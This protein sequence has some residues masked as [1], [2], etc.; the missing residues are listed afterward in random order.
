[1]AKGETKKTN[2]MLDTSTRRA[3]QQSEQLN[4]Q[5]AVRNEQAWGNSVESRDQALA[6]FTNLTGM[7]MEQQDRLRGTNFSPINPNSGHFGEAS[8][9]YRDFIKTGGI[10]EAKLH[11]ADPVWNEIMKTGGWS[12]A[13]K[14]GVTGDVSGLRTIGQYG[15]SSQAN[16]DRLRGGGVYDEFAKT[17]GLSAGNI[18]DI[19]SRATSPIAA[20]YSAARSDVDRQGRIG[21]TSAGHGA[22]VAR[23]ARDRARDAGA[24][25]LDAELGITDRVTAGRQ[26]G[27]QGM[28]GSEA[29]IASNQIA[30]LGAASNIQSG[31]ENA[32]TA[33]RL[34]AGG[35][36]DASQRAI[37]GM[38][39]Q[40]KMFGGQG[41]ESI[42]AQEAASRQ[43]AAEMAANNERYIA[44]MDFSARSQS[45]QG[46]NDIA[47]RDAMLAAEYNAAQRQG[48]GQQAQINQGAAGLRYGA[49]G[50]NQSPWQTVAG[51]AAPIAIGAL[52]GGFG[53]PLAAGMGAGGGAVLGGAAGAF[54]APNVGNMNVSN[55]MLHSR[56][57]LGF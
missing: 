33:H 52:S 16:A 42:G 4:Q 22:L 14:A 5:T 38:I 17:G 26:W 23:M 54:M 49:P 50:N 15:A 9:L 45:A 3:N 24:T 51:I 29:Q 32:I 28:T 21:G 10:N 36:L 44:G 55:P 7:T 8:S 56:R 35:S 46:V 53:A 37:Q 12:E 48:I 43:M 27:A 57:V 11:G 19:R 41:M 40:G 30:G 20:A 25:A 31:M 6:G 34:Q 47:G 2:Q 39:Q 13:A 1:M 18:A